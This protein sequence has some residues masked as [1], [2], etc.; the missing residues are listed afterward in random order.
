MGAL[1]AGG[2]YWEDEGFRADDVLSLREPSQIR[3]P[4][5]HTAIIH[6][7]PDDDFPFGLGDDGGEVGRGGGGGGDCRCGVSRFAQHLPQIG[8]LSL[9]VCDMRLSWPQLGQRTTTESLV[10]VVI[11]SQ[12][13]RYASPDSEPAAGEEY[14]GGDGW[15]S[16]VDTFTIPNPMS[17]LRTSIAFASS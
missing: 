3:P 5:T 8:R 2:A 6:P 10:D 9:G 4:I 16:Y 14:G 13:E 1:R 7:P 15:M 12:A 17:S 11:S